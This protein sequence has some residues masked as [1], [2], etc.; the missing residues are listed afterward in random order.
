VRAELRPEKLPEARCAGTDCYSVR[1]TVPANEVRDALGSFGSAIPGLSGDAVGD[2]T[3]P[4]GVR[5][6]DLRL[7]ALGLDVPAGGTAPLAIRLEISKVN[8]AVTIVPPPAD[9]VDAPP[10]G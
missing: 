10:G 7:A 6:D 8:E 5:K 9:Q 3:V 4:V 2:V 1:F